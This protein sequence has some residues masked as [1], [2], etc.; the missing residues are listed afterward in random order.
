WVSQLAGILPLSALVDF[1]DAPRVFHLFQLRRKIPF[2][3]WPITPQAS[4]LLLTYDDQSAPCWL[5]QPGNSQAQVCLDGR[6]GDS[7]PAASPET[8]RMCLRAISCE[9]IPNDHPNIQSETGK[10]PQLL[11]L[12]V[13]KLSAGNECGAVSRIWAHATSQE[14]CHRIVAWLGWLLWSGLLVLAGFAS[15]WVALSFLLVVVASGITVY[16][17]HSD[18]PRALA[19]REHSTYKRMVI[20]ADH[21]NSTKWTIFYGDSDLVNSLLNWQLLSWRNRFNLKH[22]RALD[23]LL[24]TCLFA[25]WALAIAAAAKQGFDSYIIV[26]WIL[27][28]ILSINFVFCSER[29]ASVWLEQQAGISLSRYSATLSSRRA[30][31]NTL[32]AL[33]P[34]TF[35]AAHGTLMWLDQILKPGAERSMWLEATSYF[36]SQDDQNVMGKQKETYS[37]HYW[38]KFID[39]GVKVAMQLKR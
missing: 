33:N 14:T 39:E 32:L 22:T 5:D 31:L 11:E 10:R 29:S 38:W 30:L 28:C 3:C 35:S 13:L 25:Q 24:R 4:R 16:V 8:L 34:D 23:V 21:L 17:T 26:V 19:L 2:W 15:C 6:Y 7:Y 27:L 12:V 20:T 36:Q 1:L 37:Q 18:E 9:L